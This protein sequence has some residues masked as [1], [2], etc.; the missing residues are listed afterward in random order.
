MH[1]ELIVPGLLPAGEALREALAALRAPALE[2]LAARGR[3]NRRPAACPERWL[4]AAF[5]LGQAPL[6]A[7]ALTVFGCGGDPGEACWLRADPVHLNARREGLVLI[8][9]EGFSLPAEEAGAL[10]EALN[11]HFAPEFEIRAPQPERWCLRAAGEIA[12]QAQAPIALAGADVDANLPSGPAAP[13][14]HAVLNEA[15]MLLHGHPVNAARER[16][17]EPAINSVWFW[18]AGVMPAAVRG[19]WHSVSADDPV[20]LGLARAAGIRHRAVPES[21]GAWLERAPEE[22]RHAIVLDALRAPR[23]LR[24]APA[25]SARLQSLESRWFAPLLAALRSGRIGML[26]VELPEAGI[27]FETI[28]ADLRRFWRR[29]RNL[30]AYEA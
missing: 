19:R 20:V 7:G 10:V 28:R 1:C 3:C 9:S 23:G 21:A 12:L 4:A 5:S 22:G 27:G 16:R 13:R 26:S 25:W 24:D 15:Q 29:A 11:R 18:G 8:P 30:G 6:A 14:W 17:G 2:L